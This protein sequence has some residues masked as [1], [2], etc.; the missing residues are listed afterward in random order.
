[1]GKNKQVSCQICFK[2][3]RSNNLKGH[4]KVHEKYKSNITLQTTEEMCKDLVMGLVDKAL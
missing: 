3:M 2:F 4:M 1:M